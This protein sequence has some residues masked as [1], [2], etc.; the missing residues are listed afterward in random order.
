MRHIPYTLIALAAVAGFASAQ[1]TSVTDPVGYVTLNIDTTNNSETYIGTPLCNEV[2]F[3]AAVASHSANTLNFAGTPFALNEYDGFYYVEITNGVGA[4][5]WTDI[6][7]TPSTSSITTNDDLSSFITD[8]T[9]EIKI[10]KHHTIESLFGDPNTPGDQNLLGL[11]SGETAASADL[12]LIFD[13]VTQTP[14][15]VFFSTDE[16]DPG[17]VTPSAV[18]KANMIIP[19]GQGIRVTRAPTGTGAATFVQHGSVKTGPTVIAVEVGENFIAPTWATGVT[20]DESALGSVISSGPTIA[21]ADQVIYNKDPNAFELVFFSTDEFDPGWRT[22]SAA[23]RG[24]SVLK[25][26]T[27]VNILNNFG[28]GAFNWTIP[29]Q[30][31]DVP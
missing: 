4:G 10:R 29:A 31:I 30:P 8:T 22:A 25:E 16:F 15:T 26:G 18:N 24:S 12:L 28:A 7:G 1:A 21:L 6:T 3:G 27:C 23:A 2:L 14:T 9:T 17:W 13:P 19:P 11:V 20:F 5:V